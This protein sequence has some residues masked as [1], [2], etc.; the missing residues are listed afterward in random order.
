MYFDQF[1]YTFWQQQIYFSLF[2][3]I[4]RSIRRHSLSTNFFAISCH[5]SEPFIIIYRRQ[6]KLN[7]SFHIVLNILRTIFYFFYRNFK[8]N[9]LCRPLSSSFKSNMA[10]VVSS[11][12]Y[13]IVS[14][15]MQKVIQSMQNLTK[16]CKSM[17]TYANLYNFFFK[18]L[19][20]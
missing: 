19:K 12:K 7:W 14:E 9:P 18:E 20:H 2:L 15:D 11:Q 5:S 17:H 16:V 4:Y 10:L 1:C 13:A 8:Y 3:F 6:G